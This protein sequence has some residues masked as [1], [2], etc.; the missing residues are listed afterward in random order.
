MSRQRFLSARYST[1]RSIFVPSLLRH[2][3]RR[4]PRFSSEV[5]RVNPV[6]VSVC[7]KPSDNV[8]MAKGMTAEHSNGEAGSIREPSYQQPSQRP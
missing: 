4:V 3:L 1:L 8:V 5:L 6:L 2:L 7:K